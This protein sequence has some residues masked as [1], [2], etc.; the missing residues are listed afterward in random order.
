META[1]REPPDPSPPVQIR[2]WSAIADGF[3]ALRQPPFLTL[4]VLSILVWIV[5]STISDADDTSAAVAEGVLFVISIYVQIALILAA[6]ARDPGRATDP[7]VKEAFRRRVVLKFFLAEILMFGAVVLGVLAVVIGA[8]L[9]GGIVGL[10]GQ[11]AVLERMPPFTAL[12]RSAA[13]TAPA[14][15]SIATIF[16]VTVLLPAAVSIAGVY[17]LGIEESNAVWMALAVPVSALGTVG[18][19]A[20]TRAFVALGGERTEHQVRPSAA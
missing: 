18:V 4:F 5:S 1:T 15:G 20:L 9:M 16:A 7:W 2:P 6:G 14:R 17:V 11:A 10:A 19:I 13:L 12:S 8:F 3:R